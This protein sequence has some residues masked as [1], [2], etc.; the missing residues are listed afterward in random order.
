[1]VGSRM[2]WLHLWNPSGF[3]SSS[4][5]ILFSIM[6]VPGRMYPQPSPFVVVTLAQFISLSMTLTWV[7]SPLPGML[8]LSSDS[9]RSDFNFLRYPSNVFFSR[10]W[11][12]WYSWFGSVHTSFRAVFVIA[13]AWTISEFLRFWMLPSSKRRRCFSN[14]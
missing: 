3:K 5:N 1:M 13:M 10:S 14:S 12:I 7:V 8:R 6:P 11:L 9:M 4:P 2:G